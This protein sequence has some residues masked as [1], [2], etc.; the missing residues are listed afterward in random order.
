MKTLAYLIA[1][2]IIIFS[3]WNAIKIGTRVYTWS[4]TQGTVI[5]SELENCGKNGRG[6]SLATISYSYSINNST[7]LGNLIEPYLLSPAC[8]GTSIFGDD[9]DRKAL[10][11]KYKTNANILVYFNS[12]QPNDS[13]ILGDNLGVWHYIK[14]IFIIGFM[15]LFPFAIVDKLESKLLEK[16]NQA[17]SKEE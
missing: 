4:N 6:R 3:S 10:A 17:D 14:L 2:L 11:D 15:C 9:D 16:Y 13:F 12:E 1:G 5:S 8:E 7:Y